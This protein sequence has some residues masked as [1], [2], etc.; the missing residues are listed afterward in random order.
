MADV[1]IEGPFDHVFLVFNTLFNL[2]SQEA[3]V[4]CF[5]NVARVLRPGGTFLI[6]AFVPRFDDFV[7]HQRVRSRNMTRDGIWLDASTH[8]SVLQRLEFQRVRIDNAGFK[9]VPLMLRYAY[10]P[11]LDLMAQLAGLQL[12]DRWGGWDK[13]AFDRD[14]AMH[15]SVYSKPG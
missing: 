3:Q 11:E 15:V 12:Q 13:R 1:A 4:R 9:L 10:P 8:N 2:I 7:D 6:E 5:R 14:S